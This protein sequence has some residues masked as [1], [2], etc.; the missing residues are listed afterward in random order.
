MIPVLVCACAFQVYTYCN[1]Q[2]FEKV[3]DRHTALLADI[4]TFFHYQFS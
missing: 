3:T 4:D 2:G 1:N